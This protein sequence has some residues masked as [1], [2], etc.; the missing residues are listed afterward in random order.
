[1]KKI[2]IVRIRGKIRVSGKIIDTLDMLRLYRQN[3]C[4]VFEKTP[5]VVGMLRTVK[6][7]VTWG[8]IDDETIK[9]ILEKRGEPHPE[10]KKKLKSYFRLSPPK[11]GF[12]RK[13]IKKSYREGG[14]LGYRGAKI[15]DLIL[16][17]I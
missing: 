14:A 8:E 9:L 15:K 5:S 12:E 7:Y 11:G 3:Y 6:D 4:V 17:M 2:A 13:G 1:M 16:R 10:D